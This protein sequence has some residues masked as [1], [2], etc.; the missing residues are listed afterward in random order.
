MAG[1]RCELCGHYFEGHSS[2]MMSNHGNE[3]GQAHY[4]H[5]CDVFHTNVSTHNLG[6]RWF[7][8]YTDTD[9]DVQE[10]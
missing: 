2:T 9:E 5:Y 4:P 1:Q 3:V 10:V 6:C 8:G 7:C